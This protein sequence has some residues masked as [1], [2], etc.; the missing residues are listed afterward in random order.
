MRILQLIDTLHPGGAERMA[1]NIANVFSE[2]QIPNLLVASRAQGGLGA[3]VQCQENLAILDKKKTTDWKAFKKL[4]KLVDD[5][6]P[7]VIHAH[8][9]S[10]YWGVALKIFRSNLKLIWHDHLGISEDVILNNPRKE[11]KWF[12]PKIDFIITANESTSQYW[13]DIKLKSNNRIQYLPNFP[14]LNP[15]QRNRPEVFTF[16][17]LANYRIEK[18]QM[19]LLFAAEIL[20]EKN[21]DFRIRMIGMAIDPKWYKQVKDLVKEKGLEEQI[22]VEGPTSDI[23][24]VLSEVSAG[25][26]ASDREGLPVALLE[27]GL[28]GLPVISTNVGQCAQVLE[29]GK[30][31][32][33]V[34]KNNPKQ[35]AGEMLK[36]IDSKRENEKIGLLFQEHVER[37]FGSAQFMSQ[38][39]SILEL[40]VS[41]STMQSN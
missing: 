36:L 38:Y 12:A 33:I 27:Y 29:N 4:L 2:L 24:K 35:Y 22:S 6:N 25:L 40:L 17:H 3:L 23:A 1:V 31:G 8:S 26:V 16:L 7:D 20:K 30:F 14:H 41:T 19:S 10:I 9:T 13:S 37:N 15:I 39:Q 5:F 28:A 32:V 21:V 11:L 34:E 18:G